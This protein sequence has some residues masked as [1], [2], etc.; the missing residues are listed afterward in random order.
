MTTDNFCFY[1]QNRLIQT[2]QEVNGTVILPPL[3]FPSTGVTHDDCFM[4]IKIFLYYQLTEE[5]CAT[6][7]ERDH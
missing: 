1:F 4:V 6:T 7:D 5:S 3:V 2:K